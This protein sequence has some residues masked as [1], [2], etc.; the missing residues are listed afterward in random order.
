MFGLHPGQEIIDWCLNDY[1]SRTT[2]AGIHI[3]ARGSDSKRGNNAQS[4]KQYLWKVLFLSTIPATPATPAFPAICSYKR[5]WG[6]LV[7]LSFSAVFDICLWRSCGVRAS[8]GWMLWIY[9]LCILIVRYCIVDRAVRWRYISD[10]NV[11]RF[12]FIFKINCCG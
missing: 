9:L 8:M 6:R 5:W 1:E 10:K 12:I 4:H 7:Y 2:N 11:Y 3:V